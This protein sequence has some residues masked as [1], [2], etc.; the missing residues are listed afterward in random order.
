MASRIL[1]E[2]PNSRRTSMAESSR[3]FDPCFDLDLLHGEASTVDLDYHDY[4]Q[5]KIWRDPLVDGCT[6][7][8]TVQH[9]LLPTPC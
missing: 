2:Y 1:H 7:S 5:R 9:R 4:M 3:T 8:G 6:V